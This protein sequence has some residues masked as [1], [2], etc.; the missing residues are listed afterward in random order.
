MIQPMLARSPTATSPSLD[1]TLTSTDWIVQRKYDGA[2]A[3]FHL[4]EEGTSIRSRTGQ[5]FGPQFPELLDLHLRIPTPCLLDGE[6]LVLDD[7]DRDSLERLQLRIQDKQARRRDEI[8]VTAVFFDALAVDYRDISGYALE[9]RLEALGEVL[10][11]TDFQPPE[12][13]AAV[14]PEWEGAVAKRRGSTYRFGKRSS[15]WLK[16]KVTQRATLRATGITKGN[17]SRS[18]S[19]GAVTFEDAA[20]VHR[21]QVGT[22]FSDS[23]IRQVLEWVESGEYPLIEVEYAS[24]SKTGLLIHTRYKGVRSDKTEADRV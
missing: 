22:G 9:D 15:D 10:E 11:G 19:F 23:D 5:D 21:G 7:Q 6:V 16:F 24:V 4:S 13:V 18:D 20:G 12:D 17:G 3:L 1:E 8:P 2:R 14:A